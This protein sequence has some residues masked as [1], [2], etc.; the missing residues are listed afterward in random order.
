MMYVLLLLGAAFAS[1]PVLQSCGAD[2]DILTVSQLS[3]S[4]DPPRPGKDVTFK[5]SGSLSAAVIDGIIDADV[6]VSVLGQTIP[7]KG[8]VEF[9]FTPGFNQD[10][11]AIT[12]GPFVLPRLPIGIKP[13]INGSVKLTDTENNQ[14]ACLKMNKMP[15]TDSS[16]LT[17]PLD[18][19][20]S[21]LLSA[22]PVTNCG[23]PDDHL[24]N[25]QFGTFNNYTYVNGTL[26][27]DLGSGSVQADF[28]ISI[29]LAEQLD[30]GA[31]LID[32]NLNIDGP[33]S[34]SPPIPKGFVG[35]MF[36]PISTEG[37]TDVKAITP[38]IKGKLKVSDS[39][40][41]EV[42][43]INVDVEPSE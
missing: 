3:L 38:T 2:G 25:L 26:D 20:R 4:P 36:H 17:T 8:K 5:M 39:N 43:C 7:L 15:L 31:P 11:V 33:F 13:V 42:V 10:N 1:T 35:V 12:V 23:T 16:P 27:E 24:E 19:I 41:Q 6:S 34:M 22:D 30:I 29:P 40:K 32:I 28:K 21:R 14:I 18:E 37:V 9:K